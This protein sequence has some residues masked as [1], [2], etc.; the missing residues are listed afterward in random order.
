VG[1]QDPQVGH[2][3]SSCL[4]R[5]DVPGNEVRRIHL[6]PA[7]VAQHRCRLRHQLGKCLDHSTGS[8][9]LDESDQRVEHHDTEHHGA[10][11]EITE[12]EDHDGSDQQ[13]A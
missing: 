3:P 5:H 11:R 4:D 13:R 6:R 10:V 1:L 12:R 7:L 2:D 9:L 8:V